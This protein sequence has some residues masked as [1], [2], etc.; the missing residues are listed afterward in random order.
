MMALLW[1]HRNEKLKA[2]GVRVAD[3]VHFSDDVHEPSGDPL[4][5]PRSLL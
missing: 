1:Y 4:S 5:D 3:P 2:K